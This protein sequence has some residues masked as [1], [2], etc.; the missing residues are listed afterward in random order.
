MSFCLLFV[1][2]P[3]LNDSNEQG[4]GALGFSNPVLNVYFNFLKPFWIWQHLPRQSPEMERIISQYH[5]QPKVQKL[6]LLT[7]L[8]LFNVKKL[9]ILFNQ[10][11]NWIIWTVCVISLYIKKVLLI[12]HFLKCLIIN[13]SIY[14]RQKFWISWTWL[15][16]KIHKNLMSNFYILIFKEFYY[17]QNLSDI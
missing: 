13:H 4:K 16:Q 14:S 12:F 17:L 3:I 11:R 1:M 9:L 2:K 5:Y 7:E 8:C 6:L 10:S 15:L